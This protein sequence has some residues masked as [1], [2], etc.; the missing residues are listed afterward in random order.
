MEKFETHEI[1]KYRLRCKAMWKDDGYGCSGTGPA[2]FSESEARE[3]A[4]EDGW[5]L[6]E[7]TGWA[8]P[9]HMNAKHNEEL[10]KHTEHE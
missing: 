7:G 10:G 1:T 2:G 5:R 3:L 4:E 9:S 6:I 8:C